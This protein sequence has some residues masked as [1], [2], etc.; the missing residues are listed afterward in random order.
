MILLILGHIAL[1]AGAAM[2]LGWIFMLTVGV[3]HAEWLPMLPTIGYWWAVIIIG[4]IRLCIVDLTPNGK[5]N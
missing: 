1:S 3:I 4:L 2:G 5:S